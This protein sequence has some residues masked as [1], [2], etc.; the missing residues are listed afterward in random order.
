M[1]RRASCKI[2]LQ[3]PINTAAL[4]WY[5]LWESNF[6]RLSVLPQLIDWISAQRQIHLQGRF[7]PTKL[8]R[9]LQSFTLGLRVKERTLG[10]SSD[11]RQSSRDLQAHEQLRTKVLQSFTPAPPEQARTQFLPAFQPDL[12][13]RLRFMNGEPRA[14][15]MATR[16]GV[17]AWW[18]FPCL[19]PCES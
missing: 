16:F 13:N 10:K 11:E 7:I 2:Y 9:V 15:A 4:K 1:R 18:K 19:G 6:T 12:H 8:G 5:A 14:S 17:A 3:R